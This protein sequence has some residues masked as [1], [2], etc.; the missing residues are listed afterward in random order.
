MNETALTVRPTPQAATLA[1]VDALRDRARSFAEQSR[2]AST[3]DAY[4]SDW[5]HFAS[6]C[7]LFGYASLPADAETVALYL[8]EFADASPDWPAFARWCK[9]Q[10]KQANVYDIDLLTAYGQAQ[11]IDT[12]VLH[13]AL[14]VATLTRRLAAIS[15][16]HQLQRF[17]SPSQSELVRTVLKG[18]R[19]EKGTRQDQPAPA[20]LH[21]LQRMLQAVPATL[22]GTRDRALLL[23]GFAGALRRSNIVALEVD[24]IRFQ[25]AGMILLLER[26]KTD[27]EAQGT[28]IGIVMGE[29][30]ETCPVRA[31]RAWLR[32]ANITSGFVFRPMTKHDT[33]RQRGL[34]DQSVRLVIKR[35]AQAAGLEADDFSA[36][37]LRAGLPT[38]AASMN[39]ADRAIADQTKH[40]SMEVLNRY[41]RA[42]QILGPNNVSGRVGL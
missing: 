5:A 33:V 31:L 22:G 40:R 9:A 37:S 8:A 24:H 41:I 1:R 4:A 16:L 20:T 11:Q 3:K 17:D 23:V 34:S 2:A 14:K 35:Y 27:Q 13:P 25:A 32:A 38:T 12:T 18:I 6:W 36:H 28:E 42:G 29:H 7:S 19:R 30:A 26:S 15:Q 39:I 10:R 21:V